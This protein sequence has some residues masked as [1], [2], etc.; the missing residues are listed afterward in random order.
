MRAHCSLPLTCS[1]LVLRI[2]TGLAAYL[3]A[4]PAALSQGTV[5]ISGVINSYA[6]ILSYDSAANVASLSAPLSWGCSNLVLVIQMNGARYDSSNSPSYGT[7]LDYNGAGSYEFTRATQLTGLTVAFS[8]PLHRAYDFS[9]AVQI[10]TVPVY[11]DAIVTDTL[12]AAPWNGWTGG[13]LAVLADRLT[14]NADINA[15]G[16]GFRGGERSINGAFSDVTEYFLDPA[17]ARAAFKGEGIAIVA[18]NRNSARGPAGNGGGGGNGHNAGG[19]GGGNGGQGGH[20]GLEHNGAGSADVG[21]LGGVALDFGNSVSPRAFLGGGGGGG[22][23]NDSRGTSGGAGGGIVF[24]SARLFDGRSQRIVVDGAT[25]RAVAGNDGAGGGGAGGTICFA[26]MS[27]LS[28]VTLSAQGGHGGNVDNDNNTTQCHGPGG[29]GAGGFIRHSGAALDPLVFPALAGGAPG[30]NVVYPSPC[31]NKPDGAT[32]GAPGTISD[33][34]VLPPYRDNSPMTVGLPDTILVCPDSCVTLS[35]L[36]KGGLRPYRY[37]W[38]PVDPTVA[39]DSTVSVCP[40]VSTTYSVVVTDDVGCVALARVVVMVLPRVVATLR[41]SCD[42]LLASPPDLEYRWFKDGLLIVDASGSKAA[43]RGNGV[44]RVEAPTS[45]GCPDVTASLEVRELP[46]DAGLPD[47]VVVCKDSCMQMFPRVRG[48]VAPYRYRWSPSRV[49]RYWSDPSPWLCPDSSMTCTVTVT[50]SCGSTAVA[51][52]IVELRSVV[53]ITLLRHGDTLTVSPAG[54]EYRWFRDGAAIPGA[55]S[56]VL[57]VTQAG[58]YRVEAVSLQGCLPATAEVEILP[59]PFAL[60]RADNGVLCPDSCTRLHAEVSGGTPP[61]RVHWT[62]AASLSSPESFAPLACPD[63][64]TTYVV[65]VTDSLGKSAGA[66]I[67]VTVFPR[68]TLTMTQNG[69]TLTALPAGLSYR[70]FRDGMELPNEHGQRLLALLPGRYSVVAVTSQGCPVTAEITVPP[71]PLLVALPDSQRVCPDS[72]VQLHPQFSGGSPPYHFQWTPPAFLSSPTD[73]TPVACP[74]S[75]IIYTVAVTDSLG[76]RASATIAVRVFP[77]LALTLVRNADTLTASPAGLFYQWF[78]DG[79]EVPN[80]HGQRLIACLPGRYSVTVVTSQGCPV[81]AEII[82]LPRPLLVALPDSQRVCPDSCVQ[83]HPQ[84]SGGSPPYHFQWTPPAFLSSPTDSTPVACPDSAIIYTVAVTD[85]LGTRASATIAVRVFP[86]L[87]LTLV[88][89]ADT[90][91]ASP[92]GLFYQW[93][94][95]GMEV[96][97][98]HGQ[99]LIACLPGRYSVTVVTSQGCPVMA[100]IIILPR[101]LLVA[102]PDSQRVCPDSCVQLH[103]QFSGGSPPYHFQW[104]PPAFLSSPTD[105]TPV[106]CPDSAT[107]YVL[108]VTDS[109]GIMRSAAIRVSI[110]SRLRPG[111]A[112][113]G[114]TLIAIPCGVRTRWYRNDTLVPGG[115]AERFVA[116][117]SGRYT[118]EVLSQGGCPEWSAP[119]DFR[120][121]PPLVATAS[122][123]CPPN[124]LVA[125]GALVSIPVR[126]TLP[127]AFSSSGS[128]GV[129]LWLH[130][131]RGVLSPA[132]GAGI[133]SSG[134]GTQQLLRALRDVVAGDTACTRI[135]LDSVTWRGAAMKV[136][137]AND[138]CDLCVEICRQGGDRL[139]DG[140]ARAGQLRNHPDPFNS[141]TVIE[142]TVPEDGPYALW[143]ED[144][145]GRR[146]LTL[147]EGRDGLGEHRLLL[148]R[149][150]LPSGLYFCILQTQTWLAR[151]KMIV[152]N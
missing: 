3:G 59:A 124:G 73:S 65:T 114:D 106:A 41:R 115:T 77:R 54:L 87:A 75:A 50:D 105:S 30:W 145:L 13:V 119:L 76:T 33:A 104:T 126:I 103:P 88:R 130:A 11:Y 70:W 18:A 96:P 32:D 102:L 57:I 10:V 1:I 107:V 51:T 123:R 112:R 80:E 152:L 98:E 89:N 8:P 85:S 25:V 46:L 27:V 125:P 47:T 14:L 16:S 143:L 38:S 147:A 148:E 67:V 97:N 15:L 53:T 140:T 42:S 72:C 131:R 19:A 40:S 83:L 56:D 12:R 141:S 66:S 81:M 117:D 94:R 20:G 92:A 6:R 43:L 31:L 111:I 69:D 128:S 24:I 5:S 7:V 63:T 142:F 135:V 68:I 138:A 2:L 17:S 99:R 132:S 9:S 34:L 91:T 37:A 60:A 82:I 136:L 118:V 61:L 44:Y 4:S 36:V 48:G 122:L 93:F 29:G 74:D 22:H 144:A 23:Q 137:L 35:A 139:F 49:F 39:S 28:R 26:A 149:G 62:P 79:M 113:C 78:R 52:V 101:P 121:S 129:A 55:R 150:G 86:R 108:T 64:T 71:R 95:D 45:H 134:A 58:I 110:A 90:L 116:T 146:Q 120:P 84:F 21:G 151:K 133:G 109:S 127:A 100:E